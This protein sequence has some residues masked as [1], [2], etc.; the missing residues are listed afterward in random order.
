M[1]NSTMTD[2]CI[3]SEISTVVGFG[4]LILSEF[5]AWSKG[6]VSGISQLFKSSCV[7]SC[8]G[9]KQEEREEE[10]VEVV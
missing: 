2:L 9:K 8:C 3:E 7:S 10:D 5:L 4:L 1:S 6:E